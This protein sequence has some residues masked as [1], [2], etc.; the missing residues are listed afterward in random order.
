MRAF[1]RQRAIC[2]RTGFDGGVPHRCDGGEVEALASRGA[3]PPADRG[4]RPGA[5]VRPW[6]RLLAPDFA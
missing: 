6:L 1:G 4:H 3:G 5:C 2:R